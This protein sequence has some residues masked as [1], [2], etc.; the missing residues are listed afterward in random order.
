MT[1]CTILLTPLSS[2]LSLSRVQASGKFS[3]KTRFQSCR[4]P[5]LLA[6]TC[7]CLEPCHIPVMKSLLPESNARRRAF[8]IAGGAI[9]LRSMFD[10]KTA[11]AAKRKPP[12][13]EEEKKPKNDPNVSGVQAK[14]IASIKRKE[15]MRQALAKLKQRGKLEKEDEEQ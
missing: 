14:V 8:V 3:L 10:V 1:E 13:S 2:T 7:K 11:L 15:A 4:S 5:Q 9:L 6:I 12:S